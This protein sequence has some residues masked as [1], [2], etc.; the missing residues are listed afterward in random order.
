[1]QIVLRRYDRCDRSDTSVRVVPDGDA[2][3]GA[4][5]SDYCRCRLRLDLARLRKSTAS[6]NSTISLFTDL[7][8]DCGGMSPL[9]TVPCPTQQELPM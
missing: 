9:S 8:K 2:D 6:F 3:I 1:M 7:T 5:F 4:W